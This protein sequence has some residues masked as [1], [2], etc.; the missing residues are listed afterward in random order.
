MVVWESELELVDH[1]GELTLLLLA[2]LLLLLALLLLLLALLLLPRVCA[3]MR[4]LVVFSFA[5]V[6]V[7]AHT[8]QASY[9]LH[10]LL[11]LLQLG[12]IS[13]LLLFAPVGMP[14]VYRFE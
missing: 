8:C 4:M 10:C 3:R 13:R 2:L 7:G 12:S 5:S 9:C 11:L 1:V 6:V 14:P